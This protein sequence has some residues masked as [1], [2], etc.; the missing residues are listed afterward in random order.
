M[1]RTPLDKVT[2]HFLISYLINDAF[3]RRRLRFLPETKLQ[4]LV[5]LSEKSMVDERKKG[6]NFYFIKLTHGPYSAELKSEL[7]RLIQI[8][9][10]DDFGLRPTASL[11][12]IIEDFQN[13]V[14]KNQTFFQKIQRVN[15]AYALMPLRSLLKNIYS[16][17]WGR[18]DKTIADLP[19]RTPMLYP[20]KPNN[21]DLEFDITENEAENL[22]MNFDPEAIEELSQAT[23]D[24]RKGRV[25]TY[26]Q[27]FPN[28]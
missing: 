18:G 4:K 23:D 19:Q 1:A 10:L 28:L 9:Y 6:F 13:V 22:F 27:V 8:G 11:R 14:D 24:M 17:P 20:M 15:D 21:I 12:L 16:M 5:F 2:D 3:S 26:E 25:R 7:E